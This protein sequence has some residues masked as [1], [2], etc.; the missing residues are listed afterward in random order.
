MLTNVRENIEINI[1]SMNNKLYLFPLFPLF[2][3]N[4]HPKRGESVLDDQNVSFSK[5]MVYRKKS[6]N[7]E[8]PPNK[9]DISRA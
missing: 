4:I 1:D 6:G 9:I 3:K 2:C 7:W 8:H 5:R